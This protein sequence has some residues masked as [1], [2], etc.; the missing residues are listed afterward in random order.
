MRH[1]SNEYIGGRSLVSNR[2]RFQCDHPEDLWSVVDEW[3]AK[4]RYRCL[5]RDQ[6]RRLYQKGGFWSAPKMVLITSFPD[7]VRFEAWLRFNSA[8]QVSSLFFLPPE[9]PI[10]PGGLRAIVPKRSVRRHLTWLWKR[11]GVVPKQVESS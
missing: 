3:A 10:T 8:V 5:E 4:W 2:T 11:L 9:L 6:T 1:A 7:H